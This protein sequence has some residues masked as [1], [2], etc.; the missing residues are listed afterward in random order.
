VTLREGEGGQVL[1]SWHHNDVNISQNS[2]D[3]SP[4]IIYSLHNPSWS[5]DY[6]VLI[7]ICDKHTRPIDLGLNQYMFNFNEEVCMLASV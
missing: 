4:M 5:L 6:S 1:D 3:V 7:C 2:L